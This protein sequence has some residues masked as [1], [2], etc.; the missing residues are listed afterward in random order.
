MISLEKLHR[1]LNCDKSHTIYFG[2]SKNNDIYIYVK[3]IYTHIDEDYTTLHKA[4]Y[5]IKPAPRL[6]S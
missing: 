1:R 5:N 4:D 6:A 3:Y 2:K